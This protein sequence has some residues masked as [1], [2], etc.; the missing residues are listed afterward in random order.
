M[1]KKASLVFILVLVVAGCSTPLGRDVTAG[2]VGVGQTTD[3]PDDA[4][5]ISASELDPPAYLID[6]FENASERANTSDS[7]VV[8]GLSETEFQRLREQFQQYE[9]YDS[10]EAALTGYYVEYDDDVYRV[11]LEENEGESG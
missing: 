1:R 5:I 11:V 4:V 8:E 9:R 10:S 3:P 2:W 7:Q 6:A